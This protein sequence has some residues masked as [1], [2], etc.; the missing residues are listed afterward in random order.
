MRGVGDSAENQAV[1]VES[2]IERY[3]RSGDTDYNYAAWPSDFMARAK[4]GKAALSTT[5]RIR[6]S[7]AM[8]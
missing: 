3:L 5:P 8:F 2:E 4:E 7:D 6:C 1:T